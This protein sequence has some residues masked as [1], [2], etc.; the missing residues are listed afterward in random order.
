[1]RATADCSRRVR[2]VGRLD[3]HAPALAFG[4]ARVHAQQVAG[5]DRGLVA[6]GARRAP[7]GTARRRRARPSAP[8]ARAVRPRVPAGANAPWKSSSASSANSGRR[9]SLRRRRDRRAR[10]LSAASAA[11]TGSSCANSR[12]NA[13]K[14][15]LSAIV[16]GSASSRSSSSR[17]SASISSLRRRDGSMRGFGIGD[18]GFVKRGARCGTVAN[19]RLHPIPSL[20][21]QSRL[22]RE[23]FL[24]GAREF[25]VARQRGRAQRGGGRVQQ[26]VG[27]RVREVVE[28]RVRIAAGGEL[29]FRPGEHVG[30]VALTVRAGA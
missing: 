24:G 2:R 3:V 7:R 14:R 20:N 12:E 26:A 13:R 10:A 1:M 8:V 27:Q 30:A 11:A 15:S 4:V 28:H 5:E 16:E 25:G 21:P 23:Q 22:F 6:A 9:A 19:A 18:S 29:L 17:R